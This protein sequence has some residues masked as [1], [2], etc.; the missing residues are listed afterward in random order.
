MTN[1]QQQLVISW[2][3]GAIA[4]LISGFNVLISL[5]F[6]IIAFMF[7]DIENEKK[8]YKTFFSENINLVNNAKVIV[9]LLSFIVLIYVLFSIS[10]G[11]YTLISDYD[12]MY[13]VVI[14]I[15]FPLILIGG[16][17]E[18]NLFRYYSNKE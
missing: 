18:L 17:F 12:L 6:I 11:D 7:R 16:V 9:L 13:K 2:I 1:Q 14:F 4:I 3:I 5:V 10:I 8:M 15:L